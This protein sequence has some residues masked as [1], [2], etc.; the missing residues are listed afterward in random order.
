MSKIKELPTS[1]MPR[2]KAL[3]NGIRSLSNRELLAVMIGSGTRGKSALEV[4]DEI[5]NRAGGIGNL[6]R[7]PQSVLCEIEGISKVKALQIRSV[8]ELSRRVS[9]E[10]TMKRRYDLGDPSVKRWLI[11]E[12]GCRETENFT[13]LYLNAGFGII[14]T[15]T[16]FSGTRHHTSID[17]QEVFKEAILCGASAIVLAHNH[18]GGSTVPSENDLVLT[19]SFLQRG[20]LLDIEVI[21]HL[22][23]TMNTV[24]SLK[25]EGYWRECQDR[26]FKI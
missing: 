7:M 3:L 11:Q 9:Y 6:S 12:I 5:L 14:Q 1:E 20:L 24:V 18:P 8:F 25:E 10:D 21:D 13:V 23:V 2:E 19:T 26:L 22:I 16:P 4:A 15:Q 17:V